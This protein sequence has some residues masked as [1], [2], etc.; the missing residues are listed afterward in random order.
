MLVF[1]ICGVNLL[2]L[3]KMSGKPDISKKGRD[4]QR[5]Q[6]LD[7]QFKRESPGLLALLFV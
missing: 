7:F 6:V 5:P 1:E 4:K 2:H 3:S